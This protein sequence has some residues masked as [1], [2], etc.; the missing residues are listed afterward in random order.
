M[1]FVCVLPQTKKGLLS[2]S[3]S[4]KRHLFVHDNAEITSILMSLVVF[5]CLML[6]NV[7]C[8]VYD[9]CFL[10][11]FSWTTEQDSEE[12]KDIECLVCFS[13]ESEWLL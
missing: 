6:L 4:P 1:L 2:Q 11:N 3:T 9:V 5:Q 8:V 12:G 7:S 13:C 10:L